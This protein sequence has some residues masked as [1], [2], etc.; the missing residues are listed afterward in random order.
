MCDAAALLRERNGSSRLHTR[1]TWIVA[2]EPSLQQ[3]SS[4]SEKSLTGERRCGS[5]MKYRAL[6][7]GMTL[8]GEC[9]GIN[10][11][12]GFQGRAKEAT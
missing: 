4:R 12:D 11:G 3:S 8:S 9:C 7:K 2:V 10:R 6:L 5:Q 1:A